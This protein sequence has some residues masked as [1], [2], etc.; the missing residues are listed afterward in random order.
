MGNAQ[1]GSSTSPGTTFAAWNAGA[2]EWWPSGAYTGTSTEEMYI[3]G[4]FAWCAGRTAARNFTF[5][6]YGGAGPQIG[7]NSGIHNYG[8]TA[9]WNSGDWSGAS[10]VHITGSGQ[11]LLVGFYADGAAAI[12][13]ANDSNNYR[14]VSSAGVV[15]NWSG[16]GTIDP[17]GHIGIMH[18]YITY[19]KKL[20]ISSVD[21]GPFAPGQTFH[22][23]G[24]SFQSGNVSVSLNGTNCPT[25]SVDSDGQLTVT[26]PSGATTGTVT[27]SSYAGSATSSGTVTVSSARVFRTSVWTSATGVFVD[28]TAVQTIATEVAVFRTSVWTPGA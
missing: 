24:N 27:V 3:D 1:L 17:F 20:A 13:S 4:A 16:T 11:N 25:F 5:A 9:A 14:E 18:T 19:W 6:I 7:G 26:I 15:G 22:V 10:L 23:F 2:G 8:T 28:R 21:A 12:Y